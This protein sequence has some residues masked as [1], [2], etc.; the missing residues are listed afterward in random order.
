[1]VNNAANSVAQLVRSQN[2]RLT[3]KQRKKVFFETIS[4]LVVLGLVDHAKANG[5]SIKGPA[6]NDDV[7][8]LQN[9]HTLEIPVLANDES[10]EGVL[11]VTA[12]QII[13]A[14]QHGTIIINDD[15]S[16]SYTPYGQGQEDNFSY[17]FTDEHGVTSNS[18][19]VTI[20]GGTVP[21][22]EIQSAPSGKF[23][24]APVRAGRGSLAMTSP[25]ASNGSGFS[26]GGPHLPLLGLGLLGI[27]IAIAVDGGG[28]GKEVLGPGF[29]EDGVWDNGDPDNSSSLRDH[30]WALNHVPFP[31][32]NILIPSGTGPYTHATSGTTIMK[33]LTA[34]DDVII[35][36][37]TVRLQMGG[38]IDALLTLESELIHEGG[39]LSI[40]GPL[41]FTGTLNLI[42]T[43]TTHIFG[44]PMID[45][46]INAIDNATLSL[47]DGSWVNGTINMF[48]DT[49][50]NL[51][52]GSSLSGTIN[53]SENA[54][55]NLQSS[56]EHSVLSTGII[57]GG[58]TNLFEG[59]T[60]RLEGGALVNSKLN[61]S[62]NSTVIVEENATLESET[63]VE[64]QFEGL[65]KSGGLLKTF[66]KGGFGGTMEV[67]DSIGIMTIDDTHLG[68][69]NE[70]FNLNNGILVI[71]ISSEND[72][73]LLRVIDTKP[74][75][76]IDPVANFLDGIL[77][78]VWID[79]FNP[80]IGDVYKFAE[81]PSITFDTQT[82]NLGVAFTSKS[83]AFFSNVF[84]IDQNLPNGPHEFTIRL[85]QNIVLGN[86]RTLLLDNDSGHA[87]ISG[88]TNDLL[89]G[90]GGDDYLDGGAGNDEIHGGDGNDTVIGGPGNDELFGSAGNDTITGGPGNDMLFG[91]FGNDII[92]GGP[93]NDFFFEST[94]NNIYNGDSGNDTLSSGRDDEIFTGGPGNDLFKF[95]S[96][97]SVGDGDVI[98][99]FTPGPG[100]AD[101]IN[102]NIGVVNSFADVL[103]FAS[104][105][106]TDT[107][108]DTVSRGK[109]TLLGVLVSDL[110]VNDFTFG[111]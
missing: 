108:I 102:F 48:D 14:P 49:T 16:I 21:T 43:S 88:D 86:E 2:R 9:H 50:L 99:D 15:G 7:A 18:A 65:L 84:E 1:V 77:H 81:A 56:E 23:V 57:S 55:L 6:A 110:D 70:A 46:T 5:E 40:S 60:L 103:S 75:D 82:T 28:K 27:G 85:A 80:T 97:I 106:G 53:L 52:N 25:A 51:I 92:S 68:P 94:G 59:S 90:E 13:T 101:V 111:I 10:G 37:G 17:S 109:V 44:G 67:G 105:D 4:T 91:S 19:T 45:G 42:G 3:K 29:T 24:D 8:H 33:F 89:R 69:G 47:L 79:G 22:P 39:N 38:S 30:N 93:G 36:M 54:T 87:F 72:V 100:I 35:S 62:E 34:N 74:F 83:N 96:V 11:Q 32:V 78:F 95:R 12:I 76:G 104:D 66:L 71:Q 98:T 73:D 20:T 41:E 64:L 26:F 107:V 61:L 58:T 63:P 31:A